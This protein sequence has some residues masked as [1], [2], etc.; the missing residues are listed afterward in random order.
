MRHTP[1]P[2]VVLLGGFLTEPFMYGPTRDRLLARGA[3]SVTI[4]P[5]HVIDWLAAGVA[6]LG[7]L[8]VRSGHAIRRAHRR[9]GGRPLI[10]IGHS[11][12]GVLARLAM[13]PEPFRGRRA[14]VADLVGCLVTLGT[15]HG[16][17]R[18]PVGVRHPG[19]EATAFLERVTPGA[20]NAPRTATL[21]TGSTAVPPTAWDAAP[22]TA[23][24]V[25]LPFRTVVGPIQAPG[26]DGIVGVDLAHL[27]GAHQLTFGDV[28]HGTFGAPW[29]GD[30]EVMDRWWP[31]AVD[32]WHG[33]LAA[34]AKS[35]VGAPEPE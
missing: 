1:R 31:V 14:A 20:F 4:A 2:H 9:T 33:A 30:A 18:A 24:L 8:L 17:H 28:L 7:P 27:P 21:T 11:G 13:A 12:G 29:Y 34:R 5:V 26:G 22:L 10:V 23:R 32:L 15:P 19:V 35:S 6:G 25:N 16:L 3:A